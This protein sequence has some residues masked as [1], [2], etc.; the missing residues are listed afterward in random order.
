MLFQLPAGSPLQQVCAEYIQEIL[1][2][3]NK[4]K[5]GQQISEEDS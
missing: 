3:I 5:Q 1:E 4:L 2:R